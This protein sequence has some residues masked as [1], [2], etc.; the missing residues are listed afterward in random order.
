MGIFRLQMNKFTLATP[1]K[2]WKINPEFKSL[3]S[4]IIQLPGLF[5][6][7]GKTIYKGRNELKVLTTGYGKIVVKSFGK[8]YL[9]NRFIY[10]WM[11]PSKAKRSFENAVLLKK[12]KINTPTPVAYIE[13]FQKGLIGKNMYV[14]L[15]DHFT[16]NMR[17]VLTD[18]NYPDRK[19]LL[20]DFAGF[21]FSLYQKGVYH[22][23]YSPGNILFKKGETDYHFSL[24]D[25]NRI[26]FGMLTAEKKYMLFRRLL[27]DEDTLQIIAKAYAHFCQEDERSVYKK[28]LF[29]SQ[30]FSRKRS[31]KKALKKYLKPS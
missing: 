25:I 17:K 4:L 2:I 21:T 18:K 31:R 15:Y 16:D 24:V 9:A 22:K 27:A 23:D 6:S 28:I 13:C 1:L 8:I 12:K 7:T 5:L 3:E 11:R 29:Y 20:H 26:K 19:K 30:K 14:Y 10:A